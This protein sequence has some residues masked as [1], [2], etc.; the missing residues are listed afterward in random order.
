M[1]QLK[2]MASI[3]GN[4]FYRREWFSLKGMVWGSTTVNWLFSCTVDIRYLEY[5]LS[6]TF[7]MS[8]F[9]FGPSRILINFPYKSVR[10]LKLR[11]VELFL[12]RIIFS[13]PSVIFG[14]F[15]IRYSNK[16]FEWILLF[17]SGIQIL[18]TALT[19]LCLQVCSFFISTLFR[20]QHVHSQAKN[21]CKKFRREMSVVERPRNRSSNKDLKKYNVEKYDVL[22]CEAKFYWDCKCVKYF[23]ELVSFL[24]SWKRYVRTF[25]KY[26]NHCMCMTQLEINLVFWLIFTKNKIPVT[27]KISIYFLSSSPITLRKVITEVHLL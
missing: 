19:K 5:P 4:D 18:I 27:E 22:C 21:Q 10:Y 17:I 2:G 7:T 8:N 23:V 20:Q 26:S 24:R 1:L 15:L 9:L 14:L 16:I 13:V 6:R 12:C 11:Y 25:C 3:K